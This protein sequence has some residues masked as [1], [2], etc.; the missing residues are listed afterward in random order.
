MGSCVQREQSLNRYLPRCLRLCSPQVA[1][2]WRIN[3]PPFVSVSSVSMLS[4]WTNSST[5]MPHIKTEVC[6]RAL[7]R[8]TLL[9]IYLCIWRLTHVSFNGC[10][11]GTITVISK[12]SKMLSN[13]CRTLTHYSII[14]LVYQNTLC[15]SCWWVLYFL[16]FLSPVQLPHI[17]TFQTKRLSRSC[18]RCEM[19]CI[20]NKQ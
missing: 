4:K 18:D 17:W 15:P 9:L 11:F 7:M 6:V 20:Y 2:V 19:K 5:N 13:I 16:T 14:S 8:V 12:T 1:N 3:A 10:H